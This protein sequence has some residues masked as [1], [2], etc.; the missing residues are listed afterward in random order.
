MNKKKVVIDW[1]YPI[2]YGHAYEKEVM[3]NKGLYY[4]SRLFGDKE[5]LIY[6]GKT[7][8]CYWNR[9]KSH[10]ENWLNDVKGQKY[11]RFGII[12]TPEDYDNDFL[13]DV[14][15]AIIYEMQPKYNYMKTC[16]Y[17]Y[18]SGYLLNIENSGYHGVLPR[19]I[20][21]EDHL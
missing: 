14:E 3:L 20:N 19:Y 5:T 4:I 7:M 2:C 9:L 21:S 8:D 11:V 6:I 16:S 18:R 15:S 17:T 1:S 13:E 12:K 10:E